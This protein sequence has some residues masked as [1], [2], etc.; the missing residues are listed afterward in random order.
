MESEKLLYLVKKIIDG[1]IKN[2][3]VEDIK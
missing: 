1:E 2:C 3:T